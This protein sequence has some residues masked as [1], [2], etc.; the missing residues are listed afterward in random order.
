MQNIAELEYY[1]S[2]AITSQFTS[3]AW[4]SDMNS[5]PMIVDENKCDIK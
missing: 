4:T 5:Q 2:Y 1:L 3:N